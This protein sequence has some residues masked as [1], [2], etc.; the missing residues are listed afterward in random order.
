MGGVGAIPNFYIMEI[1]YTSCFG[2]VEIRVNKTM[3]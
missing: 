2:S 1:S 3:N